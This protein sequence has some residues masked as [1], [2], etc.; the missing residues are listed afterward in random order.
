MNRALLFGAFLFGSQAFAGEFLVKYSNSQA[1]NMLNTMS[2]VK[3]SAVHVMDHNPNANIVKV[4]IKKDFETLALAQLLSQ[5]G[6]DYVVPNAKMTAFA[7][8]VD[9]Q[10]LKA[11]W[12]LGK[13]NAEKAWQRA[14]NKGSKNIIVAVIDTGVDYNHEALAPNM[15]AGYNFKDKN[16]DPMDKTSMQNPGHG[17][18]C[19]GVIAATGLVDGGTVGIAPGVSIMPLRFLG[20]N[21]SGDLNDAIKAIDYAVEKGAHVISASWGATIPRAQAAPLLEAIKR[22]DDKGVIF[23]AA[24]ANDGKNNDSTDVFPANNGFPNSITV[25]ASGESDAKPSWSNY[26]TA[27]VHLASPGENIMSTLPKNKYGNLSGTSMAT[28][29]VSGIVALLKAQ[30]TSLSGAQIR[31]ILQTSG[32]KVSIQTACNCRVDAFSAVDT[33]LSK[34]MVLV[35]A[36][37]TLAVNDTLGL[38]VLNGKAPF[39][40][41]SS[42]ASVATVSDSG[43]ITAIA[44]GTTAI[45]VTDASGKTATTLDINVGKKAQQ[46]PGNPGNPGNPGDGSCPI[47]DQSMCDILCQIKPDLPFC[48]ANL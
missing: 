35:P 47:G 48:K 31:A 25:A 44:Q 30:D 45:T 26:G 42:N 11:Q 17:T 7:A 20:E 5:P 19:A 24:A 38:S 21:G 8:P 28:P 3:A 32:A 15:I 1:F 36:A 9:A 2:D 14:G 10:A 12:A 43:V 46:Q 40:Y 39:K 33:V 37:G 34:K 4:D 16:N 23:V 29:L 13:V 27:T 6:V 41:A 18:H 22:A